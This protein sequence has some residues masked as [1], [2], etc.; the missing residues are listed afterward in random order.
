MRILLGINFGLR[1]NTF[2][3]GYNVL[4]GE[5]ILRG[6]GLG[7]WLNSFILPFILWLRIPHNAFFL[8]RGPCWDFNI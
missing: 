3:F 4:D 6:V 5:V 1:L 2:D 8:L 7:V